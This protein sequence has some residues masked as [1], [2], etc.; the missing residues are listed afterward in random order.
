[1]FGENFNLDPL[2]GL[3]YSSRKKVF[4]S[5]FKQST[6]IIG[7]SGSM[8]GL[9]SRSNNKNQ[10]DEKVT[11]EALK[12]PP[13]PNLKFRRKFDYDNDTETFR[14]NAKMIVKAIVIDNTPDA[15]LR[16][17]HGGVKM[18][19]NQKTGEV[20]LEKPH[21]APES[22]R[23][24][25]NNSVR[26]GGNQNSRR[27]GGTGPYKNVKSVRGTASVLYNKTE[28]DELFEVLDERSLR[29]KLNSLPSIE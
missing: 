1:M 10:M 26:S 3:F 22:T 2:K 21:N 19:V 12:L 18:W 4:D 7:R 15:W 16:E 23:R 8:A 13:L 9:L 25:A 29:N 24:V 5:N 28:V 20:S 14:R 11:V 6:P 27:T 17:R